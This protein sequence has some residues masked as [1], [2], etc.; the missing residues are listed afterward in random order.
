[1]RK[2]KIDAYSLDATND[3][4]ST[5]MAQQIEAEGLSPLEELEM[6]QLQSRIES[7]IDELPYIYKQLIILRHINELS[8]DEIAST[9]DLPLG[10]VKNRIFRGREMLKAKLVQEV[11]A[12]NG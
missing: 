12:M 7:A 1:M 10:T 2:K 6:G 8:Y 5:S 11:R 4:D 3:D 9:V